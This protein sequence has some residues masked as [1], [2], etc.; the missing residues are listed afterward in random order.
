MIY[1]LLFSFE[2]ANPQM[3]YWFF[4]SF[5]ASIISGTTTVLL[6]KRFLQRKTDILL[7]ISLSMIFFSF[8]IFSD[9]ITLLLNKLDLGTLLSFAG[10]ALGNIFLLNF[11]ENVFFSEKNKSLARTIMKGLEILVISGLIY[12]YYI[13]NNDVE[14]FFL[15]LHILISIV[16]YGLLTMKS[17][18]LATKLKTSHEDEGSKSKMIFLIGISGILL[19]LSVS[20]FIIHELLLMIEYREYYS[21]MMG[22]LLASFAAFII[23]LG[24]VSPDWFL[25]MMGLKGNK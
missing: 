6:V 7:N 8:A 1:M 4:G 21:L 3:I 14:F 17:F 11:I 13:I 16:I 5:I 19:F 20:M 25:K 18:H 23:Y 22:W 15:I 10:N 12:T 2:F 9:W 24:Y